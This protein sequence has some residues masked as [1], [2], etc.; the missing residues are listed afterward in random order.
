METACS[1]GKL[2]TL[3]EGKGPVC[4]CVCVCERERERECV[5]VCNS[6]YQLSAK[7]ITH[8]C[9]KVWNYMARLDF[10]LFLA[11]EFKNRAY[12]SSGEKC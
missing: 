5:Y 3:C 12:E 4:V 1:F 10:F 11:S 8:S 7:Q 9:Q 2:L 6:P